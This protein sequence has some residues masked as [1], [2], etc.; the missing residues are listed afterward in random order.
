MPSKGL[1]YK[2][3]DLGH[4]R[5]KWRVSKTEGKRNCTETLFSRWQSCF[6]Q[7]KDLR[8]MTLKVSI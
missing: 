6:P 5:N 1:R 7:G 4:V 2:G 8:I 3:T